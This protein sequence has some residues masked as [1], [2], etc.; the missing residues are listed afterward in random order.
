MHS[1]QWITKRI[2]QKSKLKKAKISELKNRIIW[3][4]R[5]LKFSNQNS[6]HFIN[7]LKLHNEKI[8]LTSIY[9]ELSSQYWN[10]NINSLFFENIF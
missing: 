8:I 9:W 6:D 7:F 4:N 2:L 1:Y 5:F 3:I 10:K